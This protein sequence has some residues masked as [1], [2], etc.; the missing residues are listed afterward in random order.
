MIKAVEISILDTMWLRSLKY[1]YLE[2]KTE[3]R[4]TC[5]NS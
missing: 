4:N 2:E 1:E 5:K 3:L